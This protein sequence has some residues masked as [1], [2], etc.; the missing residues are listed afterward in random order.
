M[1]S[2]FRRPVLGYSIVLTQLMTGLSTAQGTAA[3]DW[4][5][6][7]ATRFIL[8]APQSLVAPIHVSRA[9]WDK[10]FQAPELTP[11]KLPEIHTLVIHNTETAGRDDEAVRGVLTAHKNRKWSDI[12]YHFLIAQDSTDKTWKVYQG[13][14]IEYFGAHAGANYNENTIGI[15]MVG[16]YAW[17][18]ESKIKEVQGFFT[19]ARLNTESGQQRYQE[20]LSIYAEPTAPESDRQIS[21]EAA[22]VLIRLV[23]Q[24][25]RDPRLT[26]LKRIRSHGA[27]ALKELQPS[28]TKAE[29]QAYG[30]NPFH[31]D[32][33]GHGMIHTVKALQARYQPMLA[34]RK[35]LAAPHV[36]VVSTPVAA[37]PTS[38]EAKPTTQPIR[39]SH[40]DPQ[41]PSQAL[42]TAA[43]A[44]IADQA[45][46]S[47]CSASSWSQRGKA[48]VG[49]IPGMALTYAR[50]LCRLKGHVPLQ[51]AAEVMGRAK[52]KDHL[53]DAF[54]W[55]ED[56]FTSKNLDIATSGAAALKATYTLLIGLG[57]R[58][59]TG[60]H[61]K[62]Y[63]QKAPKKTADTASAGLFQTSH[64]SLYFTS[65]KNGF[66]EHH[67][68]KLYEEYRAKPERCFLDVFKQGVSCT[69][70]EPFGSGAGAQFQQ[71]TKD[72]PA[73][74]AESAAI[75]LRVARR[76][77]GPIGRRDAELN[78]SCTDL[79]DS[80]EK[81]IEGNPEGACAELK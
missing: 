45:S 35:L 49:Y 43:R 60:S 72:C 64:N 61:C 10:T 11:Q 47:P 53:V 3:P 21:R 73:F 77:Y 40:I 31:T 33:A 19:P 20:L 71:F 80:I 24:L 74:A 66:S 18:T 29:A 79:L 56:Q 22:D 75:M 70:Q 2:I 44:G 62:G 41:Q 26:G 34:D 46:Q 23:D 55:Y 1:L 28:L 38:S 13:R 7:E 51:G 32:C 76:H 12:G 69:N 4:T 9:D 16:A 67:L 57:M 50:S 68:Q 81:Q 78:T 48:P 15:A 63:H 14:P 30:I 27:L 8:D 25:V 37:I 59:S 52:G 17:R 65:R 6:E 42:P 39:V 54:A 58:E 5:F 36:P